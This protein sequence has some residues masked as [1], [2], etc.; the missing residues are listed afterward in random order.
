MYLV[1]SVASVARSQDTL[2][3][4]NPENAITPDLRSIDIR[5]LPEIIK[6]KISGEEYSSWILQGAFKTM[7][8]DRSGRDSAQ[9]YVVELRK[10]SETIRVW[11]DE[12][13]NEK[14]D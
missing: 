6:Q 10:E 11:F 9:Y 3:I 8:N 1:C 5:E 4:Q 12:K 14:E 7:N 13:G 2:K